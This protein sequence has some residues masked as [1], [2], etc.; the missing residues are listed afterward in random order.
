MQRTLALAGAARVRTGRRDLI[1]DAPREGFRAKFEA[2]CA[3]AATS[4]ALGSVNTRIC[5]SS[6]ASGRSP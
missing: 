2:D 1:H 3:T 4:F 5:R 6:R